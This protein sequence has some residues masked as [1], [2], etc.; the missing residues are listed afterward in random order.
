MDYGP[1]SNKGTQYAG[2]DSVCWSAV[3]PLE[4]ATGTE[5]DGDGIVLLTGNAKV[6]G[7]PVLHA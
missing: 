4:M 1:T 3:S 6:T 5:F 7:F 2:A